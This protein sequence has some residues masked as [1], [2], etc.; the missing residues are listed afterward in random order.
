LLQRI[1]Q[2]RTFQDATAVQAWRRSASTR[3]TTLAGATARM[4]ELARLE[5]GNRVLVIGA[6]TGDDALNAVARVGQRGEVIA[7]DGSEAMVEE[8]RQAVARARVRNVH[9]LLMDAQQLDFEAGF[10]DAV[11]ARNVLQFI[12]DILSCL[13]EV[14]RVL[15]PGRRLGAT[16]WAAATRNPA[17]ADPLQASRAL[18]LRPP[19]AAQFRVAVRLG[20]PG[21]LG[22]A[23][24]A[25][26]F[27]DVRVERVAAEA[28]FPSLAAAVDEAMNHPGT[29]QLL[30]L[31]PEGS[32]RRFAQS[33]TR[34]WQ[35][36]SDAS[37]TVLPGEQLVGGGMRR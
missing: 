15:K 33:L 1:E 3:A 17:R 11:V 34:R 26:G 13:N 2:V 27:T 9:C 21:R 30:A 6:G 10:F 18:G 20:A 37:G 25:A 32:E 8:M 19:P 5:P 35:R 12:P 7:T 23:L 29:R 14:R 4:L 28:R 24:R 31:L 36:Y 16:V 22:H